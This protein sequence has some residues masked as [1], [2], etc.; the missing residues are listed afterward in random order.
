M[1]YE[2]KNLLW[3]KII[4]RK[5]HS[6]YL[7]LKYRE[8]NKEKCDEIDALS[9]SVK[10]GDTTNRDAV[11]ARKYFVAFEN[12]DTL[13]ETLTYSNRKRLID[14]PNK[15]FCNQIKESNIRNLEKN[16]IKS[17]FIMMQFS[18]YART[19]RNNDDAKKYSKIVKSILPPSGSVRLLI[20]TD[21]Q[22][23]SMKILIGEKYAEENY[24]DKRD[25]IEL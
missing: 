25:I 23:D 7:C 9:K 3:Q 18:V 5:I 15:L 21:R 10:P 4:E 20:I 2:F 17:G 19:V 13:F 1:T 24:L 12:C 11:A 6:R 22:Y 8:I 16:L 14:L